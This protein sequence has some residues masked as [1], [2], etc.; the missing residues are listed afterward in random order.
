MDVSVIIVNYNSEVLVL[1][2][3]DSILKK[4]KDINF[5]IIVI[6]NASP[7]GNSFIINQAYLNKINFISSEEN[8]GFGRANNLAV[9]SASG[10]YIFF[11]NPD[12]ILLNNA[13]LLMFN[14]LENNPQVGVVG[15]NLYD[16]DELPMHSFRVFRPS[17]LS[18][19]D[20]FLFN[21]KMTNL[22]IRN[23]DFNYTNYPIKIN[24]G[25]I[26]G[27]DLMIKKSIFENIGGFEK[28]IFMYYEDALLCNEVR[29]VN[30]DLFSLPTAK[31]VHLEG[32]SMEESILKRTMYQKNWNVYVSKIYNRPLLFFVRLLRL[33][34]NLSRMI[35]HL[36]LF[37]KDRFVFWQKMTI[38]QINNMFAV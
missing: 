28:S 30:Y 6:D 17:I 38:D 10:K 24:K 32:K 19:L 26:T 21:G 3:I 11:L 7:N 18:E 34:L 22:L 13:I 23:I 14:F 15:G 27:A 9:K 1:D 16:M 25:Y 12:T 20:S 37:R 35:I 29:K 5:E 2:C 36:I 31:I 4:T 8:L 33:C